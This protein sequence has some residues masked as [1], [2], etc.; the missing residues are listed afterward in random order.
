MK[1]VTDEELQD[2]QKAVQA[3][4]EGVAQVGAYEMQKRVFMR[5]VEQVETKLKTLQSA[6]ED[7]YGQITVNLSTGEISDA[8][9]KKD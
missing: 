3:V 5:E 8:D 7:K 6:L 2:L 1:K 4:N 9:Y